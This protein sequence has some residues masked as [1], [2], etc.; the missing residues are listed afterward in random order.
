M[1]SSP[2]PVSPD[3]Q[4]PLREILQRIAE[5][6]KRRLLLQ[7]EDEHA[8][9]TAYGVEREMRLLHDAKQDNDKD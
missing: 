8:D 3:L 4:C 2:G 9:D 1:S 6:E 7:Q 5:L